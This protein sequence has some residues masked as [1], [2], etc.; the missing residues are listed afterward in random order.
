MI[1]H[2]KHTIE[3]YLNTS[4]YVS[5][6]NYYDNCITCKINRTDIYYPRVFRDLLHVFSIKREDHDSVNTILKEWWEFQREF[7]KYGI[8]EKQKSFIPGYF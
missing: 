8:L 3:S 4:Y 7:Y 5:I 1:G 6:D 2:L